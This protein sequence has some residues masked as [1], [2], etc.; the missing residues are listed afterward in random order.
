MFALYHYDGDERTL[1]K[2]LLNETTLLPLLAGDANLP[3]Y[4]EGKALHDRTAYPSKKNIRKLFARVGI[5][6]MMGRLSKSL[7]RD[8]DVLIDSF[9]GIRTALAHSAPPPITINDVE[10]LLSD[11]KLIVGAIDRILHG[12][13]M[14]HGGSSCWPI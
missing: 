3:P 2:S 5:D 10:Q 8:A 1:Y 13:V 12:H 7:S 4:F 11:S 6:D 14:R 9:Q